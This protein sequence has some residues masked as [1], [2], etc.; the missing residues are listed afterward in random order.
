MKSRALEAR[1]KGNW[2]RLCRA[3]DLKGRIRILG[4]HGLNLLFNMTIL[5]SV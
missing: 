1:E 5:V 3:L 4:N 2:A